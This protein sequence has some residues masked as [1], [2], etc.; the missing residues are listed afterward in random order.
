[1]PQNACFSFLQLLCGFSSRKGE[2]ARTPDIL[3]VKIRVGFDGKDTLI[4]PKSLNVKNT[5]GSFAVLLEYSTNRVVPLNRDGYAGEP[6][7]PLRRYVVVLNTHGSSQKQWDTARGGKHK[8]KHKKSKKS[9]SKKDK[10]DK[11]EVKE[12]GQ[13]GA[14][15]GIMGSASAMADFTAKDFAAASTQ[16]LLTVNS[17]PNNGDDNLF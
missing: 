13:D 11:K 8:R 3:K 7:D 10:K 16:A 1:M 15:L 17:G 2:K 12:S 4:D 6:L 14:E 9:K 5:F